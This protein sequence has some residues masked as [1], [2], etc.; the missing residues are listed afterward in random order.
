MRGAVILVHIANLPSFT[1]RTIYRG[2]WDQKNRNRVFPGR[3]IRRD[4]ETG[5]WQSTVEADETVAKGA[6]MARL[7]D[8]F[9]EPICMIGRVRREN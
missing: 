4:H 9:G 3:L 1:P 5:A 2:P 7:T 6:R 8:Y